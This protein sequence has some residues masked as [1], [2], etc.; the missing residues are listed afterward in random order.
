MAEARN[1]LV[2]EWVDELD[3]LQVDSL[4]FLLRSLDPLTKIRKTTKYSKKKTYSTLSSYLD[5]KCL[6]LDRK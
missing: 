4:F 3:I 2:L 1:D 5:F 6:I